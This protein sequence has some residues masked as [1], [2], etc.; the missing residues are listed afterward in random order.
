M[1]LIAPNVTEINVIPSGET[2]LS[3]ILKNGVDVFGIVIVRK[4]KAEPHKQLLIKVHR[5]GTAG[6]FISASQ[7]VNPAT[8]QALEN[9]FSGLDILGVFDAVEYLADL[10]PKIHFTLVLRSDSTT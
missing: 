7:T 5:M 10:M 6:D 9:F 8:K 4:P 2:E 1:Y 3:A